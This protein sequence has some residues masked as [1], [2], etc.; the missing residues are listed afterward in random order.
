MHGTKISCQNYL[1][2]SSSTPVMY[3]ITIGGFE[4]TLR[5]RRHAGGRRQ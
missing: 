5:H 1:T 4:F 3:I 2:I